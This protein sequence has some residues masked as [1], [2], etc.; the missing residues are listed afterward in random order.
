MK[1][2]WLLIAGIAML[3][4]AAVLMVNSKTNP[5]PPVTTTVV[6]TTT[7]APAKTKPTPKPKPKPKP[8]K[9]IAPFV[10]VM[11]SVTKGATGMKVDV[12]LREYRGRAVVGLKTIRSGT[13]YRYY[14]KHKADQL[15][16][17]IKPGTTA[18]SPVC[19]QIKGRSQV[20]IFTSSQA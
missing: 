20:I 18:T 15:C 1:K 14:Y 9:V 5:P 2:N 11:A 13:T 6:R 16:Q 17:V 19:V 3:V 10:W 4:V 8:P 7:T 12:K